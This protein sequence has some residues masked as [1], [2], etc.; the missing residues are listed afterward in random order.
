MTIRILIA[1]DHPLMREALRYAIE[2]E[3]DMQLVGEASNGE[4]AIQIAQQT[5]PDI[6]LLD[7]LMPVLDGLST[8]NEL[9]TADPEVHIL[10]F[11]SSQEEDK[12]NSAVE[13]GVLG[14]LNKDAPRKDLLYAIREVSQGRAYLPPAIAARLLSRLRKNK[15]MPQAEIMVE[16]LTPREIEVADWVGKGLTNRQIADALTLTEGTVR[17]HVH[18]IL[19][20]LN[21]Q[22]RNQLIL[23]ALKETSK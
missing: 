4:E 10:V 14:Y 2:D 23:Y 11:T 21:L 7:L 8:I 22:N 13:S 20:K 19:Q 12:I 16:K 5:T 15:R 18:N 1:D 3:E 6:I 17:T 9:I